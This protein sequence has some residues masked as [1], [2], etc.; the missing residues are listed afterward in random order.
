MLYKDITK[1]YTDASHNIN[2]TAQVVMLYEGM[3]RYIKNAKNAL[4]HSDYEAVYNNINK[5]KN[6]IHG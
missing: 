1:K 2:K 4:N 3:I 5:T 6:I